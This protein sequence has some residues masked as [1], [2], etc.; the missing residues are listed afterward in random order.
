MR[1]LLLVRAASTRATRR[2]CFGAEDALDARGREAAASLRGSLPSADEVLAGPFLAAFQTA[3]VAGCS[4]V[5]IEVALADCDYGRWSGRPLEEVQA[6]DPEGVHAWLSDPDAAPHGGE[7]LRDLLAR[8][9]EW[10][11]TQADRPGTVV[12]VAPG[13]VV[14]AAVVAA[15]DAPPSAFWRV[16]ITPAAVTEL[17]GHSGRW[18]VTRVND[19]AS[20]QSRPEDRRVT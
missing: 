15:L 16:D 5:K 14:K 9:A 6:Q 4:P 1:R 8:V 3:S 20:P 10:L 18:T 7:T 17:H 12:A 13:S 19:R 2:A 11:K